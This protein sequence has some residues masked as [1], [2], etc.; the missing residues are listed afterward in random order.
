LVKITDEPHS[1]HLLER[2]N[3]SCVPKEQTCGGNEG[4]KKTCPF[5]DLNQPLT[6]AMPLVTMLCERIILK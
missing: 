6:E 2:K 1:E 5:R 3:T 4:L